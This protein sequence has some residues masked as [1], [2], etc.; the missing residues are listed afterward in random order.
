MDFFTAFN[1]L[2]N[3]PMINGKF[4]KTLY[5]KVKKIP[6]PILYTENNDAL[7]IQTQI[8]LECGPYEGGFIYHDV[9]L[10]CGGNTFEEAI[11]K[12]SEL[13]KKYYPENK[14]THV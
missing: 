8:W 10:D 7:N 4:Q 12:L 9:R 11:L 2:E 5:I 1:F 13:V 6:T 14:E 3:H